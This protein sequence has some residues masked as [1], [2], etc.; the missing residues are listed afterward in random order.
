MYDFQ[1][2]TPEKIILILTLRKKGISLICLL[3]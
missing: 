3:F 2:K 1:T